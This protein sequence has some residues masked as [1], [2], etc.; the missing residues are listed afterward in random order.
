[1]DDH[2][3]QLQI[4]QFVYHNAPTLVPGGGAELIPPSW[5]TASA[6]QP[7]PCVHNTMRFSAI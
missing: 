7:G 1:M 4:P 3:L 6:F 2:E 5:F